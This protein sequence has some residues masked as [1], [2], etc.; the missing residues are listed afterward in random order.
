MGAWGY[1]SL[2]SPPLTAEIKK[3]GSIQPVPLTYAWLI[4]QGTNALFYKETNCCEGKHIT[5]IS[6][7]RIRKFPV[8]F[9]VFRAIKSVLDKPDH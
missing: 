7:H 6:K 8:C 3:C 1:I 5:G 4:R 2:F 9:G